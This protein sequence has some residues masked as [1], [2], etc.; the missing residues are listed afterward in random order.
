MTALEG[1]VEFHAGDVMNLWRHQGIRCIVGL[2]K[3][4]PPGRSTSGSAIAKY[5]DEWR[6]RII[7]EIGI[8]LDPKRLFDDVEKQAIYERAQG[9][10]EICK[11]PVD[12][13]D[14]EYDHF[15]L[16]H[17]LG[18]RTVIENGRLVLGTCHPRGPVRAR[19]ADA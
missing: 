7:E 9:K 12:P 14:A 13:A 10:C 11:E 8:R 18:G 16:P 17:T 2:L 1:N 15:P 3:F 19:S 5:Y 4:P 6:S